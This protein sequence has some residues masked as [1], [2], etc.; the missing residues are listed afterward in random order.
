MNIMCKLC[1]TWSLNY[2]RSS[3]AIFP[4]AHPEGKCVIHKNYH[5]FNCDV[6]RKTIKIVCIPCSDCN[7]MGMTHNVIVCSKCKGKGYLE[8]DQMEVHHH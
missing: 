5:C 8:T 7:G 4:R 2:L 6:I 1:E 3:V